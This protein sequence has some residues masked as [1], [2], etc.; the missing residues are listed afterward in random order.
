MPRYVLDFEAVYTNLIIVCR[1]PV[2]HSS[3]CSNEKRKFLETLDL[4]SGAKG[5]AHIGDI[6]LQLF[7]DTRDEA[8]I[9]G[10]RLVIS[11]S[12]GSLSWIL[13]IAET[14]S[15]ENTKIRGLDTT[16]E[17]LDGTNEDLEMCL[18]ARGSFSGEEVTK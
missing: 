3:L 15:E 11:S 10:S 16:W 6:L 9:I 8:L 2:L 17:L 1:S 13:S 14:R 5:K 12:R 7:A 18:Q 4:L